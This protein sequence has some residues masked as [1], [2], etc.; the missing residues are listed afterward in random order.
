MAQHYLIALIL[1]IFA[2]MS[3]LLG[4]FCTFFVKRNDLRVLSI[5]L[6]FSAGVMIYISL[7]ELLDSSKEVLSSAYSAHNADILTFATFF[8][9]VMIAILIDKF[10]PD[11]ISDDTFP[12][13]TENSKDG[14]WT[15]NPYVEATEMIS[16]DEKSGKT[17]STTK[18]KIKR[19]GIITA[20]AIAIHNFPEGLATFMISSE[21]LSLG[22]PV[23]LAIAIHNIPE[24]IAVAL[25]IYNATGKRRFAILYSFLSGIAEPIGG[26]LGMLLLNTI[27]PNGSVGFMFGIVAGIMVYISFDTLLPLAREYGENHHVIIGIMSGIFVI[28]FSLL[29][30]GN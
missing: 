26:V 3:T 9:G 20:I 1:T 13:D 22:I 28:G 27:L 25:P 23:A 6:G 18:Y 16:A 12:E 2:G 24:G 10:V 15:Q 11:H 4:G 21:N 8:I 7:S 30:I 19:A 14:K 29:L 17:I 5:G